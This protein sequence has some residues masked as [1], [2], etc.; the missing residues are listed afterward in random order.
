MDIPLIS[1]ISSVMSRLSYFD[2]TQFLNKYLQIFSIPELNKQIINLKNEDIINIF[3]LKI[4][5]MIQINKKINIINYNNEPNNLSSE[6]VQYMS[7]STSN[8]SGIYIVSNKLMNTIF[9]CF[10]GTY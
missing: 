9:V 8:Y 4:K 2:D 1:L 6:D 5:N 7:I 10:R 3:D